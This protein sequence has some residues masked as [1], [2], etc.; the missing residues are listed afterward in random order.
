MGS[1][2][3]LEAFALAAK[4]LGS[5]STASEKRVRLIGLEWPTSVGSAETEYPSDPELVLWSW[6]AMAE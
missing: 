6:N 3:A 4:L 2:S 5:W 1:K